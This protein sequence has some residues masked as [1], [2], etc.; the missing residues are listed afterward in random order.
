MR[1]GDCTRG[2]RRRRRGRGKAPDATAAQKEGVSEAKDW[3]VMCVS[4]HLTLRLATLT[5]PFSPL[6]T[7]PVAQHASVRV[8]LPFRQPPSA[9]LAMAMGVAVRATKA[10][11]GARLLFL[12]SL[13]FCRSTHVMLLVHCRASCFNARC[14]TGYRRGRGG[15]EATNGVASVLR[16]S[17]P[18][19][20]YH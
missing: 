20:L 16:H 4:F 15:Q 19:G 3:R 7:P 5:S 10:A 1:K 18:R 14:M 6:Q 13:I 8:K 9:L 11:G 12:H 2:R 17:T